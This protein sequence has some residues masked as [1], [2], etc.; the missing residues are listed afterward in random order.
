[1][2]KKLL[3]A[4]PSAVVVLALVVGF[5]VT[6]DVPPPTQQVEKV[7]PDERFPR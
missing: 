7:I 2:N 5:V 6:W 4:I 1:M 3:I